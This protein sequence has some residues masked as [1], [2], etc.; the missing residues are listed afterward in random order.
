MSVAARA[1]V[2]YIFDSSLSGEFERKG[3]KKEMAEVWSGCT[4]GASY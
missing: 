1:R 2:S 4:E 3:E